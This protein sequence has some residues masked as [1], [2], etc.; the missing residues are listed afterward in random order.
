MIDFNPEKAR[1]GEYVNSIEAQRSHEIAVA[2]QNIAEALGEVRYTEQQPP[3][4]DRQE[5]ADQPSVVNTEPV[6]TGENLERLSEQ[7]RRIAEQQ[8]QG[9]GDVWHDQKA[10]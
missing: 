3:L 6:Y 8:S 4:V 2:V 1:S 5:I 10:A 9:R 7:A